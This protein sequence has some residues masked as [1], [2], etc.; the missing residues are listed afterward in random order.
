[1]KLWGRVFCISFIRGIAWWAAQG[2][3]LLFILYQCED[4]RGVPGHRTTL[5]RWS[6]ERGRN[7]LCELTCLPNNTESLKPM[8]ELC[9][10][11]TL[12]QQL[13]NCGKQ[14]QSSHKHNNKMLLQYS[15]ICSTNKHA[16]F[17]LK[18]IKG[19]W[20]CHYEVCV[21]Q[22]EGEERFNCLL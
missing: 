9:W 7:N 2:N 21:W 1:M 5:Q 6:G 14:S 11:S 19:L 22:W 4:S 3:V 10:Q 13:S 12:D 16:N 17:S 18:L 15:A 8:L 20:T